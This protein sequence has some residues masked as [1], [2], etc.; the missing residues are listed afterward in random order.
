MSGKNTSPSRTVALNRKARFEYFIEEEIEAGMVL[1]GTEVKSLRKGNANIGDAYAGERNGEIWLINAYIAEFEGGNRNN[2]E[3][4]RPRKLLLHQRQ[5]KKLLG[6]LKMKGMTL[7]PL[8]M[9]FNARGIAKVSLGLGMG[10]KQY[11][12]RG[13]IKEREW[14]RQKERMMKRG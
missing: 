11:E 6:R 9:Y 14:K 2:H 1:T 13:T 8:A 10:K 12:K 3:P 7:V 4:K 5:I